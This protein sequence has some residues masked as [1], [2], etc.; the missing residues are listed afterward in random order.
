ML[1]HCLTFQKKVVNKNQMT[2]LDK[3]IYQKEVAKDRI[4]HLWALKRMSLVELASH[5]I[6]ILFSPTDYQS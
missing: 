5:S 2:M 1:S 4:S 6:L 3:I